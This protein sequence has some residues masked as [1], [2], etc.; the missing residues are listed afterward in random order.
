MIILISPDF[1]LSISSKPFSPLE[2]LSEEKI[3]DDASGNNFEI[4]SLILSTPGPT[5]ISLS[6]DLQLAH[7]IFSETCFQCRAYVLNSPNKDSCHS[8][9]KRKS[10]LQKDT[11]HDA[12]QPNSD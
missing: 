8:K 11:F 4:S 10:L 12:I 1:I 6:A 9:G 5:G 3:C 2:K 7:S